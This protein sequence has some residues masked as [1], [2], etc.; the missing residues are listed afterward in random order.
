[1]NV[2]ST[3]TRYSTSNYGNCVSWFAPGRSI[4]SSY[5]LDDS[6]TML[7]TGTSMSAP[8]NTGVAALYLEGHPWAIPSEVKSALYSFTT[9]SVVNSSLTPANHILYS[10]EETMA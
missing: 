3:D 7:M 1:G 10:F 6:S 9:K 2:D 8:F 5:Y 4:L